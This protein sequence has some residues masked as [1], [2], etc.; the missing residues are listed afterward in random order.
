LDIGLISAFNVGTRMNT[1]HKDILMFLL[2]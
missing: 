1:D 2:L